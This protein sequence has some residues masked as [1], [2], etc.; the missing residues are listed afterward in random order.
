MFKLSDSLL[1][2]KKS[3]RHPI[4]IIFIGFF[5]ASIS[6]LLSLWI[7]P[8]YASIS[9][10]FLSIIACLYLVQGVLIVEEDEENETTPEIK[11]LEKHSKTL[12]FF[13]LL[14]LGF[15]FAF[16]FWTITLP[17]NISS[18]A[19]ALQESSIPAIQSITGYSTSS[20]NFSIIIFNNIRV[21]ALSVIFAL[22]YGAGAIFILAWNASIMGF[23][24]GSL[25]KNL[26]L[27]TLPYAFLKYFLHGIPEM[28]AYF[29]AALGGGILFIALIR[30]DLHGE[31]AKKTFKDVFI[32]LI[33]SIFLLIIAAL[34]E[35]YI[36]PFI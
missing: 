10:I 6:L 20:E 21:L 23:V 29:A 30:G 11:T 17:E 1:S 16:I 22:F 4:E 32:T 3:E 31:K 26:G 36:S 28:M 19:F 35:V 5:Y 24:I 2:P 14:F 7:F 13:T 8:E 25:V 33:L 18:T 34:I 27:T 12:V 9:M 15:L